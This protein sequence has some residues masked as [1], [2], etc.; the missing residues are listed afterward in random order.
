MTDRQTKRIN[1]A[2]A[3]LGIREPFIAAVMSKIKREVSTDIPTAATNGAWVKYNP[4]FVDEQTDAQLFGLVVHESLHV[5]LM[6]MWRRDS[7]D[8][9]LWNYANDAII[10][11]YIKDRR[12]DLPEGGV[13]INWVTDAMSSEEV[14]ERVKQE[15]QEQQE[16]QGNSGG[17]GDNDGDND[18]DGINY[19]KGGFGDSGD[20]LDAVDDATKNDLEATI[21]A[22]AQM[23]KA[24]GQGSALIDRI[25]ENVGAPSVTW[26]EVLR[27]M[28][29]S[30][31]RDDY[32]F[33]RPRRRYISQGV[34]LPSLHSDSLGGLLIGADTSGSMWGNPRE[35]AQVAAELNAIISDSRPEFVEVAYCDTEI[36]KL[37]RFEQDEELEFAPKGG[38][39]TRFEPVFDHYETS[40]DNYI[41]IVYFTD[42]C[43]DF[44]KLVNPG[45]PV[46]WAAT[47][48]R[49]ITSDVPFGTV[50]HVTL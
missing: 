32:S 37:D 12:Y 6:H 39:G 16:Q 17:D 46:I 40:D 23:A 26:R 34:Y 41:G 1:E 45:I 31:S 44:S 2:Y 30:S 49:Y 22:S 5:V 3:K 15:Q 27:N 11:K 13:F 10:N 18:G 43:A 42:M 25:L 50:V 4:E 38:G 28:M 20:L 48:K 47:D 21:V 8:P 9:S 33:Q 35:L 19:P 7:R 36:T 14:Y 24:C 29:T